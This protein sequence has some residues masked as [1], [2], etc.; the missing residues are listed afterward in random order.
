MRLQANYNLS[1]AMQRVD[2]IQVERLWPESPAAEPV[3]AVTAPLR[4]AGGESRFPAG[5]RATFLGAAPNSGQTDGAMVN[6]GRSHGQFAG[7]HGQFR[8]GSRFQAPVRF[9]RIQIRNSRQAG[10][11]PAIPAG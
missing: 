5:M 1:Q 8:R 10:R 2:E 6:S 7:S 4:L 9:H 3:S 11:R